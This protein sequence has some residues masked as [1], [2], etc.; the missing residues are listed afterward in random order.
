M[1]TSTPSRLI[2]SK[3]DEAA[4][5]QGCYFDQKAA[6]R[7][8]YFFD[9]FLRHS[10][11]QFAGQKFELLP[12]QWER[13]VEPAYGWRM[14]D[15]TRRIRRIA[16]G[17]PKKN[18]KSTLLAGLGIYHLV[19]DGEPGAE[20]YSAAADRRQASVIFNEAANMV[21]ASDALYKRV[22]LRENSKQMAYG[23]SSY[24]ALSA[25]VE[26]KE[27]LN[28]SALLF[29]E[30]H[31]QKTPNLWNAL[32]FG[33]AARRQP[34]IF[35]IS[36]AGTDT[37]SVCYLQWKAAKDV[38]DG[39]AVDIS[40]LPC[41]Y[42]ADDK[43]DPWSEETW[44]K[45]NPSYGITISKRDMQ[46][47]ADEAQRMPA[48]E[49]AFRR[50]RL[51]QW[52]RQESRWVSTAMWDRCRTG[53]DEESLRGKKVYCG[54]DL[55]STTDLNAFVALAK[56]GDK[57]R[58]TARY[59]APEAAL[60]SRERSNRQ[61]IDHW[62]RSDYIKLTKGNSVDYEVIRQD[63]N[64]LS[65]ILR[66]KP[67]GIDPWNATSLATALMGDGYEI[68][69]VRQGFHTMSPA[70]KELEKMIL[71]GEI[72]HDGNPVTDWMFGNMCVEMNAAGDV[73]P[74]K[75]RAS[76]KIDGIVALLIALAMAIKAKQQKTCVYDRRRPRII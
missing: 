19:G 48:M 57:W 18:G 55:A 53:Y 12:W 36:T 51:N 26:T 4:V 5:D 40:L 8:R 15:G 17:V 65:R 10:K 46:E 13:I 37:E 25:E 56:H 28:I 50:Y 67:I 2:R 9:R 76:D 62:A 30:L 75:G 27:G 69:Y 54:L 39:R 52:T 14:P 34:M 63:I 29:D 7:V 21:K 35:W 1:P 22:R 32:R 70:C 43:D 49:N 42:A 31:A 24:E 23:T 11:G 61:R 73:K 16:C 41:I 33:G 20:V 44:R 71:N 64:R 38:Q 3:S 47:A 68:E 59:W 58:F 74:D 60:R 72:E 66:I 6:D 45:A